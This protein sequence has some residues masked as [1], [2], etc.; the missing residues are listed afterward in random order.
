MLVVDPLRRITIA[1]I[2]EHPWFRSKI[3]MYLEDD[4]LLEQ[5]GFRVFVF[6]GKCGVE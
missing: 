1:E 3:E 2:R 4:R 6:L 5:V